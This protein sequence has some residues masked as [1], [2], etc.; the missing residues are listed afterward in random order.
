MNDTLCFGTDYYFELLNNAYLTGAILAICLTIF[1]IGTVAL[2]VLFY[3]IKKE[4]KQ[5]SADIDQ[6]IA[7]AN[8]N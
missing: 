3:G 4:A 2:G 6:A 8:S 7:L 1:V 5:N